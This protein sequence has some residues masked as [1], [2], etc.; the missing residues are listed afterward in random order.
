[1]LPSLRLSP[2]PNQIFYNLKKVEENIFIVFIFILSRYYIQKLG[3]DSFFTK[4][5]T[6]TTVSGEQS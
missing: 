5:A 1:M 3:L 2:L 4:T 6:K